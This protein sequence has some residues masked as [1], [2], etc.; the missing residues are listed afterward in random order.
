MSVA[1]RQSSALPQIQRHLARLP[2]V[3][4][5][6]VTDGESLRREYALLRVRCTAAERGEVLAILAAFDARPL[7]IS[8]NHVV[9]EASGFTQ[10]M[11]ALFAA[12]SVYGIDESARTSPIS[13][14]RTTEADDERQTA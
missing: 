2:D 12:L 1:V 5:V 4:D 3:L 7:N 14:R 10:Q 13:L 8:T 6:T 11:D 9:V